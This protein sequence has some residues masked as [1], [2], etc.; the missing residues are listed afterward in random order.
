MAE[1]PDKLTNAP[2]YALMLA[3][4]TT[5]AKAHGYA[6]AVHGSMIRDL[7]VVAIAWIDNAK[8]ATELVAS[9]MAAT[10]GKLGELEAQ[11]AY[12]QQGSPGAK[13]HGRLCW[14]LHLSDL[15]GQGPYVDLSVIP[16]RPGA[17]D[18]DMAAHQAKHPQQVQ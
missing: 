15:Y 5:I 9:L 13:P 4:M 8:P 12:F 10:G 11:E 3:T 6:L 18:E 7:D 16:P 2:C 17:R 1:K 14:S